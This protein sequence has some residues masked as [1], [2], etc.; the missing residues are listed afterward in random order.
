M[1]SQRAGSRPLSLAVA[2]RLWMV[3]A[4]H[5]A[6]SEPA[7]SQFFLPMVMGRMAFSTGLLSGWTLTVR[8]HY[9][10]PLDIR[11]G[12][13][14]VGRARVTPALA[15][16]RHAGGRVCQKSF[17]KYL[18]SLVEAIVPQFDTPRIPALSNG[19]ML[20]PTQHLK[21]VSSPKTGPVYKCVRKCLN[22]NRFFRPKLIRSELFI[23]IWASAQHQL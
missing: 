16:N 17:H 11:I 21:S 12:E 22:I 13:E 1:A 5:P 9:V 7:N 2:N 19:S 18:R 20:L 23:T 14:T 15:R 3:A 4:R 8:R 10:L 6:R